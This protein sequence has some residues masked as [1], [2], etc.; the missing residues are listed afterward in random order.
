VLQGL[1]GTAGATLAQRSVPV[2]AAV[3]VALDVSSATCRRVSRPVQARPGPSAAAG[4]LVFLVA[5]AF[6]PPFA[7]LFVVLALF[8]ATRLAWRGVQALRTLTER[9]RRR[10]AHSMQVASAKARLATAHRTPEAVDGSLE[11]YEADR[12]PPPFELAVHENPYLPSGDVDVDAIVTVTCEAETENP[13]EAAEV[14]LVDCSGSMAYPLTKLREAQRATAG[15]IDAL[16]DG[17]WFAVVRA[18]DTAEPLYPRRGLAPANPTTRQQAKDALRLLWAEGGT[19]LG[20]WLL[21]ARD[22]L[23]A[24]P[25]SIRHAI[26]LT[27]GRNESEGSAQLD[28]ALADCVGAFQCDCR[29]V[30]TDWEVDELRRISSALLGT[31][32]IVPQASELEDDFRVIIDQAMAKRTGDVTLRLW[33]PRGAEV[34]FVRQV[35][36]AIETLSG[37]A[38]GSGPLLTDYFTGA[39]GAESRAYHVALRVPG[40]EHSEEMLAGAV[41]MLVDGRV[42]GR[43][44]IKAMWTEDI[45]LAAEIDPDVAHYRGQTE[46]AAAIRAGLAARRVGDAQEVRAQF[47]RAA[48]LAAESGNE[49]TL[50]LLDRV[51]EIDD[52]V[53]G[54]VRPRPDVDEADEMALDTRS[55][56]S[57]RAGAPAT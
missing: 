41:S 47:G 14:I 51:V 16:R 13:V 28:A 2:V 54:T 40:H 8:V 57:V 39:W 4:A 34:R 17:T 5:S 10:L 6:E 30:G 27:D 12:P 3:R 24:R 1:A 35:S 48:Q 46:L 9:Q 33:T 25:N 55:T 19:A 32:D 23:L 45:D 7:L 50:R 26:L 38:S 21:A 42:A 20:S 22:L 52:A 29:G 18:S 11:V 36:P 49:A 53:S 31:V 37:S 43:A 56:R 44:L 15:A